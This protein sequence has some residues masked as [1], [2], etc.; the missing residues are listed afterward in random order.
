M[1]VELVFINVTPVFGQAVLGPVK[2]VIVVE[3]FI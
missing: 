2:L 1:C 3:T